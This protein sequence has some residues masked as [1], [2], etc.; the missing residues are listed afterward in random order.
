MERTMLNNRAHQKPFTSKPD[1]KK[2]ANNI[3]IELIT[4]RNK[5]NVRKVSGM[6]NN[7]NIGFIVKFNKDKIKATIKAIQKLSIVTPDKI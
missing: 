5:P 1:T 4:I 2:S 3:I 6:V 7:I